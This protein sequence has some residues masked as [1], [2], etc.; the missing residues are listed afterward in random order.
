MS[1]SDLRAQLCS[2]AD[3]VLDLEFTLSE[4]RRE[5][6]AIILAA[7]SAGLSLRV[8]GEACMISHQTVQNIID[9]DASQSVDAAELVPTTVD[10]P[11]RD[12]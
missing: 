1:M 6:D 9:R 11:G 12:D 7:R 4:K 3:E 8:I 5:R 10:E 2:I